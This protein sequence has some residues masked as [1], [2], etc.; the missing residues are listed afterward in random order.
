MSRAA[1]GGSESS[2]R[3]LPAPHGPPHK[4]GAWAPAA[5]HSRSARTACGLA[6]PRRSHPRAGSRVVSPVR[7]PPAPDLYPDAAPP[8][9]ALR[10]AQDGGARLRSEAPA[11]GEWAARAGPAVEA[12]AR[13]ALVLV[14]CPTLPTGAVLE[15]GAA[16]RLARPAHLRGL[17][18]GKCGVEAWGLGA[19]D[20]GGW[21]LRARV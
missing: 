2:S 6:R 4:P 9:P 13:G 19:R 18:Q 15:P 10:S 7:P 17:R 5:A 1:G 3:H 12:G 8:R 21:D 11:A 16:M 20:L 14:S